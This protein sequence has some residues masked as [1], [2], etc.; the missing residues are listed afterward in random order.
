MPP[1]LKPHLDPEGS[2]G[3]EVGAKPLWR[4]SFALRQVACSAH[5]G[6]DARPAPASRR[7]A[8]PALKGFTRIG[9]GNGMASD[10]GAHDRASLG[11]AQRAGIRIRRLLLGAK[12]CLGQRLVE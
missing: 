4:L 10:F 9:E 11:I 6:R 5:F 1:T 2:V 12:L 3:T 7:V 8:A